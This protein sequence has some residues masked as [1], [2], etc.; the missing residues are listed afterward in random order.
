M[1]EVISSWLDDP[2]AAE[3]IVHVETVPGRRPIYEDVDPPLPDRLAEVLRAQGIDRLYRHQARVIR[4]AREGVHTVVV[5]GTAAGKSLGYQV[6]IAEA[7]L[8]DRKATALLLFPTKALGRD[9]FRALHALGLEELVPVVYDGDTEDDARAW[10]RRHATA[11]VT[12][13][14]MLHVGIL[15]YHGN[16]GRFFAALRFVVVD[17]VHVLRGIFGSHVGN[18]LRRLRRVAAHYGTQPTFLGSSATIGNPGTLAETLTGRPMTVVDR[19]G[20]PAGAK[21]VV[22]LNPPLLDTRLGVRAGGLGLARRS[23][24]AFLRAGRQT[25]VFG[26]SRVAVELMLTGLREA[27]REGHGPIHRVRGYRGG[28]LPTERRAIEAGDAATVRKV[29]DEAGIPYA[30]VIEALDLHA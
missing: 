8:Q 14:D 18:V 9:Q 19:N 21:H 24:L 25:I 1:R 11:V 27:L 30:R 13:P 3:R 22:V 23:A 26:R 17:E 10:A 2:E 4:R 28:Y 15:P 16:W 29:N 12:N 7:S 6:P 20:A 5:A